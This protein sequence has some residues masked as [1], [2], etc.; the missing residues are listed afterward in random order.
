M[1]MTL[2]LIFRDAFV[3]NNPFWIL[4]EHA[5]TTGEN[6]MIAPNG[7]IEVIVSLSDILLNLISFIVA[8]RLELTQNE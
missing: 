2:S 8:N 6:G 1:N 4:N 5:F 7:T 3:F